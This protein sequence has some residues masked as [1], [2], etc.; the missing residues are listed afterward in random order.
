MTKAVFHIPDDPDTI[1]VNEHTKPEKWVVELI[2]GETRGATDMHEHGEMVIVTDEIANR[3]DELADM[4][5]WWRKHR[6]N[7]RNPS[8]IRGGMLILC[9]EITVMAKNGT[10]LSERRA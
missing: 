10:G 8:G 2:R 9:E 5:E 4:A 7:K 6:A 1:P 3:L